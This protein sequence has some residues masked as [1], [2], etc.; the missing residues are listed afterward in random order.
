MAEPWPKN[1]M[2]P[3]YEK[4][5]SLSKTEL[6]VHAWASALLEDMYLFIQNRK[7]EVLFQMPQFCFVRAALAEDEKKSHAFLI[8]EYIDQSIEGPFMKYINNGIAKPLSEA[9]RHSDNHHYCAE[10]LCFTQ[11]VQYAIS[12]KSA[13]I[14]DYQGML[15]Y[16][17][18][19]SVGD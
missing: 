17:H 7:P 1:I 9:T 13:Y 14:S 8:E 18:G 3:T 6:R 19:E 15:W 5:V 12:G 4:L 10:F 2:V 11:H 16:N